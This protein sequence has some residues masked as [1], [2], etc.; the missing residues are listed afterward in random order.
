MH[1]RN[2][3]TAGETEMK[4]TERGWELAGDG[5]TEQNELALQLLLTR[6]FSE[7]GRVSNTSLLGKRVFV[8]G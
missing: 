7:A 4:A 3:E 1:K 5:A 8:W 6:G 2:T